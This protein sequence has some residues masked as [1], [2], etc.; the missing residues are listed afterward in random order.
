[1][2]EEITVSEASEKPH[3]Q[4]SDVVDFYQSLVAKA[5]AILDV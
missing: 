3:I 2:T 4:E 5:K 1:V